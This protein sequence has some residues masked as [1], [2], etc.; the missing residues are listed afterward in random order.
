MEDESVL[1][2]ESSNKRLVRVRI[3]QCFTHEGL[4]YAV[5]E[6][7]RLYYLSSVYDSDMKWIEE[8]PLLRPEEEVH[9]F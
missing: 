5:G 4:L 7:G 6:N 1:N 8:K 3:R 2:K 9:E